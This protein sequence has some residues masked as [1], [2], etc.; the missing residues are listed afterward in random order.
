M[1]DWGGGPSNLTGYLGA[2]E[3]YSDARAAYQP[4]TKK[5]EH[6]YT[7]SF[8]GLKPTEMICESCGEIGFIEMK[9]TVGKDKVVA[10]V[11]PTGVKH[12]EFTL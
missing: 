8:H 7:S 11:V 4:E 6:V 2:S 1:C 5:H 3:R 10:R 12:K 9:E